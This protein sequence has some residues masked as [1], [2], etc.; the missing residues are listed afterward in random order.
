MFCFNCGK[1][2]QNE[3]KFC[4]FC[5]TPQ[6][7]ISTNGTNEPDNEIVDGESH[8]FSIAYETV[9]SFDKRFDVYNSLR[10]GFETR[11]I[12]NMM[13]VQMKNVSD[14]T[15]F[16]GFYEKI[17]PYTTDLMKKNIEMCVEL[18][19]NI[20]IDYLD[21]ETLTKKINERV[22]NY[23]IVN[24]IFKPIEEIGELAE[25]LEENSNTRYW[26]GGGFGFSGAIK[27][28]IGAEILNLGTSALVGGVK[29]ITGT[30]ND[31]KINKAKAKIFKDRN[32]HRKALMLINIMNRELFKLMYEI[33]REDDSSIPFI[34]FDESKAMGKF[35]NIVKM[36]EEKKISKHQAI[37][38]I[39][40]CIQMYPYNSIFYAY[41]YRIREASENNLRD[42]VEYLGLQDDLEVA[43]KAIDAG[44][45]FSEAISF[46]Y[47]SII[48]K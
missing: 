14:G 40:D 27:G 37:E 39:G 9:V 13:E 38:G 25:Q 7:D 12:R 29:F 35:K 8:E 32:L 10:C 48:S 20:G 5:G 42:I 43:I 26:S 21:S 18:L 16:D 24:E 45:Q 33:I 47:E 6:N 1:E 46:T 41:I 34:K 36:H 28:A 22:S 44:R 11:R 23:E 4:P 17:I 31:D 2:I 15:D 19:F 30:T 3:A